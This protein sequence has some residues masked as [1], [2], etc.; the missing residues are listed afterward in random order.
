MAIQTALSVEVRKK[1]TPADVWQ[2]I[3]RGEIDTHERWFELIEGEIVDVPP[4]GPEGSE[5]ELGIGAAL[6]LFARRTSGRAFGSSAGFMVG[7]NHQ[8]LRAPDASY[9]SPARLHTLESKPWADGAPD[10]AVEV[11]SEGQYGA[12]YA[13]GKVHEYFEAGAQ[14]VW[15]VDRRQKEVR[16]YRAG[17]DEYA[18]YRND[19]VLTLEPIASGF[20][21]RLSDIFR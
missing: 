9:V 14:L 18:I 6:F 5:T 11:L 2:M 17:S 4:A 10:L 20:E 16:V 7:R 3:E 15:L 1:L 8:Q 13:Y 21:L 12:A 19:A